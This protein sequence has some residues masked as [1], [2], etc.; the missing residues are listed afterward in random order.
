MKK[1][2]MKRNFLIALV[3]VL[4]FAIAVVSILFAIDRQDYAQLQPERLHQLYS[5][6]ELTVRNNAMS[7]EKKCDANSLDEVLNIDQWT[8]D[9]DAKLSE[10][11]MAITVMY[12]EDSYIKIYENDTARA[13]HMATVLTYTLPEGTYQQLL[14]AMQ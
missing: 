13:T 10:N 7:I 9:D 6:Q 8:V 14:S 5:S 11:D 3:V 1:Q 2:N 12:F 4:A